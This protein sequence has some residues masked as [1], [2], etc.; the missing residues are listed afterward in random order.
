MKLSVRTND[1]KES[2]VELYGNSMP[3]PLLES[4]FIDFCSLS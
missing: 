3:P 1:T 4:Q 2:F